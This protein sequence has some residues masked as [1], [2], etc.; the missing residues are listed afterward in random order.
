LKRQKLGRIGWA[1]S[2]GKIIPGICQIQCQFVELSKQAKQRLKWFE[3]YKSRQQNA[4]LTCRYFGISPQTFYRWK[5]R[6]NPNNLFLLESRSCVSKHRRRKTWTAEHESAVIKLRDMFPRWGKK[7]LRRLLTKQKVVLSES[8][9]GRILKHLKQS[10]RLVEPLRHGKKLPH[11]N[12]YKRPYACRKPKD[13]RVDNPG[14]LVEIDTDDLKPIPGV[15]LKHFSSCDVVSRWSVLGVHYRATAKTAKDFLNDVQQRMPFP[16]RAIQIDGGSEFRGDFELECQKRNIR[17]FELP[18]RSP[19]LNGH[20]ERINRTHD[21]EFYQVYNLP[22]TCQA[23]RPE[24]RHWEDIYNT[25][26]PHESLNDLTPQEF[27]IQWKTE[28]MEDVSPRH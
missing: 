6:F 21:E 25:V 28:H 3:F 10:G 16:V 24:Q 26:R 20:V 7:K 11:T 8:M 27:L 2:F 22:W 5:K 12:R 9:I 1:S 19:K 23:L 18:P 17:L 13:Y 15:S 14:D 4:R